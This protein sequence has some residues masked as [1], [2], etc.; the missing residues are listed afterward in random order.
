MRS[1]IG[2]PATGTIGF[3]SSRV[4]GPRRTAAPTGEHDGR[5]RPGCDPEQRAQPVQ[6]DDPA[7]R[8]HDREL[9][10]ARACISS[11]A[12]ARSKLTVTTKSRLA[13][14]SAASASAT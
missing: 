4:S 1:R 9:G 5:V 14:S 7:V 8:I 12:A 11:R 10:Q 3:G 2:R 6:T 13:C